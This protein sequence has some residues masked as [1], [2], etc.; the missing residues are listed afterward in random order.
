LAKSEYFHTE[1]EFAPPNTLQRTCPDQPYCSTIVVGDQAWNLQGDDWAEISAPLVFATDAFGLLRWV[2][3]ALQPIGAGPAASTE[4]T[5]RR[6]AHYPYYGE[7][8]GLSGVTNKRGEPVSTYR[9][10]TL[11][12][13]TTEGSHSGRLYELHVLVD[14]PHIQDETVVTFEYD[15]EVQIWPPITAAQVEADPRLD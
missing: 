6:Q 5:T 4:G 2:E 7:S 9:G 3:P 8:L 11:T 10:A 12:I 1:I 14:G 13:T 15:V